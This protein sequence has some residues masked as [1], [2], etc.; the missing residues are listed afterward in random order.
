MTESEEGNLGSEDL[1]FGM[2]LEIYCTTMAL[3]EGLA[4]N[5]GLTPLL[6]HSNWT[7]PLSAKGIV[8]RAK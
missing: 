6:W 5:I 7:S 4:N 1:L 2:Y 8:A 3:S